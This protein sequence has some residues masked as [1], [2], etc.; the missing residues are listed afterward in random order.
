MM[1]LGR[2]CDAST[3]DL[4]RQTSEFESDIADHILDDQHA[5]GHSESSERRIGR[6]VGPAGYRLA[7]QVGNVVSVIEM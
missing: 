4:L 5:L 3:S 1:Q 7:T 2:H 6:Q